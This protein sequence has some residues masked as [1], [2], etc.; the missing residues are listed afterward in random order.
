MLTH[1]LPRM[2]EREWQAHCPNAAHRPAAAYGLHYPASCCS[3]CE[4]PV[5]GWPK[6][7]LAGWLI[8]K[9]R[10]AACGRAIGWHYPA[11]E[12]LTSALFAACA[13]RFGPTLLALYGMALSAAL[14]AL[15]WIDLESRLL[16][17]ALTLPLI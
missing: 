17:D 10:C 3:Q 13:W 6:L 1:R 9:R 2:M 8:L 15:A 12:L 14:V 11:I 16:P 7:P 4:A 5:T